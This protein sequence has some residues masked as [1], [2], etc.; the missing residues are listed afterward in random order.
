MKGRALILVGVLAIVLILHPVLDSL[1]AM[2]RTMNY[3]GYLTGSFKP[4]NDTLSITFSLYDAEG[5]P[6]PS[7]SETLPVTVVNGIYSVILGENVGNPLP[8]SLF[9]DQLWLGIQIAGEAEMTPRQTLT[10][11]AYAFR[12]GDAERLEG[13]GS[14]SF[15]QPSVLNTGDLIH[16]YSGNIASIGVGSCKAGWRRWEGSAF[17]ACVG[18]VL[19]SNDI[20]NGSDDDCDPASA[21]G[22]EDP[23]NGTACDGPDSDLCLEGTRSCSDGVLVVGLF[24][25]HRFHYRHMQRF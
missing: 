14:S 5:A 2:P 11:T 1:A 18:E 16:C 4:V 7:W 9:A 15:L 3:Q 10:A 20:C 13:L 12:S 23:L 24:R 17:G 8:D 21:D 22:S 25:Q 6:A 19:P